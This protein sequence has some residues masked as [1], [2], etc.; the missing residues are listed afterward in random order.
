MY[1]TKKK[2]KLNNLKNQK[3]YY[4]IPYTKKVKR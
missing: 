4:K 2:K 1:L 3:R